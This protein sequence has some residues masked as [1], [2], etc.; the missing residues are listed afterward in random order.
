MSSSST[1]PID[2]MNAYKGNGLPNP[3]IPL[4]GVAFASALPY[5]I[6]SL[7]PKEWSSLNPTDG[8]LLLLQ[9]FSLTSLLFLAEFAF[10]AQARSTSRKS[11]FSPAA[12]QAS[13]ATPFALVETNRIHQNHIESACI[14]VPAAFS[15]VAAGVNVGTIVATQVTWVIS[16]AFYRLG[17][18][19]E[20][21]FWRVIGTVA[22]L[23][24]SAVCLGLFAYAKLK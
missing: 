8:V 23:S 13:G 21:P 17:Y 10:G 4:S 6:A 7:V 14:Y 20:N 22:S 2:R 18:I 16:R 12:A 9:S 5:V 24:Q 3:V 1:S 15:A 19:Q 11:S